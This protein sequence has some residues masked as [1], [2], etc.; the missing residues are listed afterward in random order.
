MKDEI[1]IIAEQI[2]EQLYQEMEKNEFDEFA[3]LKYGASA[4]ESFVA[5]E[6]PESDPKR[7]ELI[8]TAESDF[9]K[10]FNACNIKLRQPVRLISFSFGLLW[11]LIK[12]PIEDDDIGSA[13]RALV[14]SSLM[15]GR[16][17]PLAEFDSFS[18]IFIDIQRSA[19]KKEKRKAQL[20][21]AKARRAPFQLLEDWAVEVAKTKRGT[22]LDISH[23]LVFEIPPHIAM[24]V[25]PERGPRQKGDI[26]VITNAQRTIYEAL[27]SQ[28]KSI[29]C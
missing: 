21:S 16:A 8:A 23:E 3:V 14:H 2:L 25:R 7:Q 24:Y 26:R 18:N 12:N 20:L 1:V 27:L 13:L 10:L 11:S 28:H 15:I 17:I 29:K 4:Y 19:E 22:D 6:L 9:E 5:S